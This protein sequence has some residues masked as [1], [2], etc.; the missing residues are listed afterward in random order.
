MIPVSN[1]ACCTYNKNIRSAKIALNDDD[2][3]DVR[4]SS[5]DGGECEHECATARC[6]ANDQIRRTAHFAGPIDVHRTP[7]VIIESAELEDMKVICMS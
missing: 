4:Q 5:Y 3:D 7:P 6:N 1:P 2:E